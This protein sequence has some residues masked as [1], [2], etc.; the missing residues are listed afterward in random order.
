MVVCTTKRKKLVASLQGTAGWKFSSGRKLNLLP[1]LCDFAIIDNLYGLV[2][3]NSIIST[4]FTDIVVS[5][6]VTFI[7]L[8]IYKAQVK[9]AYITSHLCLVQTFHVLIL[10]T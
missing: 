10:Q 8:S 2:S 7:K 9:K 5:S 1:Y 4:Q 3:I 6:L